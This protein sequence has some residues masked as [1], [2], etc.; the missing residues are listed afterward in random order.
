MARVDTIEFNI[1]GD[2]FRVHVNVG[3]EGTFRANLPHAV[4]RKIGIKE[5]QEDEKLTPLRGRIMKAIRSYKEAKIVEDVFLAIEY[6]SKGKYHTD[7]DGVY[8]SA[9]N[10]GIGRSPFYDSGGF[11]N[12]PPS[13]AFGFSLHIR[14]TLDD[15]REVWYNARIENG[16]IVKRGN[17]TY[18][19]QKPGRVMIPY[20]LE[21]MK[22]LEKAQEGLRQISEILFKFI[23][24]GKDDINAQ[25]N[26]GNLL[27]PGS[28]KDQITEANDTTDD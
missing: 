2:D 13:V 6:K 27:G 14:Q 3:K 20:S 10:G 1:D 25:L 7:K 21:A 18:N 15:A 22:T 11:G 8:F 17:V 24:Q 28:I 5:R 12:E 4:A 19:T 23:T 9:P 26:R 16:E